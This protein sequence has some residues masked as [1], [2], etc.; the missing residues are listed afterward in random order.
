MKKGNCRQAKMFQRMLAYVLVIAMVASLMP[1]SVAKANGSSESYTTGLYFAGWDEGGEVKTLSRLDNWQQNEIL[2]DVHLT[3]IYANAEGSAPVYQQVDMNN[4]QVT[5]CSQIIENLEQVD[6]LAFSALE[7]QQMRVAELSENDYNSWATKEIAGGTFISD[8]TIPV[9]YYKISKTGTYKFTYTDE[10]ETGQSYSCYL[11]MK[12]KAWDFYENDEITDNPL[13]NYYYQDISENTGFYLKQADNSVSFGK[14]TY[15]GSGNVNLDESGNPVIDVNGTVAAARFEWNEETRQDEIKADYSD[16]ISYDSTTGRISISKLP[17]DNAEE[18]RVRAYFYYT[19]VRNDNETEVKEYQQG[20]TEVLVRHGADMSNSIWV[21]YDERNGAVSWKS[22]TADEGATVP[23]SANQNVAGQA[24]TV[25]DIYLTEKP[26]YP[27]NFDWNTATEEQ[28]NQYGQ[29]AGAKPVVTVQSGEDTYEYRVEAAEEAYRIDDCGDNDNT[30]WHFTYTYQAND[31]VNIFWCDYDAFQYEDTTQF[32]IEMGSQTEEKGGVIRLLPMPA[33]DSC[34]IDSTYGEKYNFDVSQI[35][36]VSV[37]FTPDEGNFLEEVRIGDTRYV[38]EA[39]NNDPENSNPTFNTREDGSWTHTFTAEEVKAYYWENG[40]QVPSINEQGNQ[41]YACIYVEA[42]FR[43]ENEGGFGQGFSW[44]VFPETEQLA[45]EG[46]ASVSYKVNHADTWTTL[47]WGSNQNLFFTHELNEEDT[48]TVKFAMNDGYTISTAGFA[49]EYQTEQNARADYV[50]LDTTEEMITAL[51]GETG[52]TFTFT[53][54]ASSKDA[55]GTP[56][57]QAADALLRLQFNVKKVFANECNVHIFVQRQA[58]IT[59]DGKIIYGEKDENDNY[60]E[61][62]QQDAE[63]AFF[64]NGNSYGG[65]GILEDE[66]ENDSDNPLSIQYISTIPGEN[67]GRSVTVTPRSYFD[68]WAGGYTSGEIANEIIIEDDLIDEIYIDSNE[69][70]IFEANEQISPCKDNEGNDMPGR[71]S[72]QLNPAEAYSIFIRKH[73]SS[74]AT[75][76]WNYIKDESNPNQDD[77]VE[78]GKVYVKEIKRGETVLLGGMHFDQEGNVVL[79]ERGLPVY[80]IIE[81]DDRQLGLSRTGGTIWAENG[82]EVTLLLVP[83]Y[84]YQLA[85]ANINGQEGKPQE[86]VSTFQITLGGNLHFGGVFVKSD[87]K[88]DV[89]RAKEIS[90]ATIANGENAADSGNLSLTVADNAAYTTD[91]TTSVK[92][93]ANETMEKV[94]TLD[95]ILENIVSKGVENEYWTNTVTEFENDITVGLT[96]DDVTLAEGESFTVVRDHE[97][98]L[99]ELKAD[100]NAAT[101]T[102]SFPTNQFSTY[103]IVKK[104]VK[105]AVAEHKHSLKKIEAKEATATTT[106]NKEY[107]IC[108][109]CG[110]VY[111]DAA[112]KVQTTVAAMTIPATG[113]PKKGTVI[114]DKKGAAFYKVTNDNPKN[115]TVAYAGTTNSKAKTIKVPDT[116]TIEGI[117]YKVTAIADNALKGNKT[118]TKVTISKNV[119]TIGKNAFNGCTKLKTVTIGSHVTTVS[120]NAFKGCKVLTKLT[121]PGST[122]KIGSNA[123][124]GCTK[125]KTLTINSKK[126]TSKSVSKDAFKGISTKTTI[127][128]PKGKAKTYKALLQKKGLSKKVKVK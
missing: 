32:Q 122:T 124:N 100:Y 91:V 112:G 38:N 107:W 47:S 40:V 33:D 53:P 4:I 15:D 36:A 115:P 125:L 113:I 71:Y 39:W 67:Y 57:M 84:G 11:V 21:G 96:L 98:K 17:E 61:E 69:N 42:N 10:G 127:K 48:I 86:E 56:A 95:L 23:L 87:D 24:G 2:N 35:G 81:M 49:A 62:I 13:R 90:A 104:S 109:E 66:I 60:I 78:H 43:S 50:T 12:H 88:A 120:A 105:Q 26:D 37:T 108:S 118:I 92:K 89:T 18:Y 128:V 110:K 83:T 64:F 68:F 22:N 14:L 73:Q 28:H 34:F 30:T 123:F 82:D 44:G 27:E 126:L 25:Y 114:L 106:G 94:A 6:S 59:E 46:I 65:Q 41:R 99:T 85:S 93:D 121:L 52:Y 77:L 116:V 70:G 80:D 54:E 55:D 20:Y 79:D 8:A 3:L 9:T 58:G 103:T 1:A 101:K 75:L 16:C 51:T 63:I 117:T 7:E 102:V 45:E 29:R 74:V 19:H 31:Q 76:S 119:I 111:S 97:G 5:Y 72:I